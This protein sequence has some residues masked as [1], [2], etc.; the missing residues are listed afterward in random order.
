[1]PPARRRL[2]GDPKDRERCEN[3]M[4]THHAGPKQPEPG[5][6]RA[7]GPESAP[8]APWDALIAFY[9]A[10]DL[11]ATHRFY[12]KLLGLP[13]YL[14]QGLCRLY[15][16]REGAYVGFCTHHPAVPPEISP[17]ITL[18]TDEVDDV[19]RRLVEAGAKVEDAPKV[20]PR[21]NIY[22]FFAR[23]PDGYRVEVQRFLE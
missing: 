20:N 19:Y 9:G 18:V 2:I 8:P 14:D 11:E 7:E 6:K 16:V 4:K 23:D 3:E 21:F 10:R 5:G 13:L 15:R 17:M 22:H 12:H 1:M